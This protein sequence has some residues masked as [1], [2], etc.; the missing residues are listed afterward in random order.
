MGND[1]MQGVEKSAYSG[2]TLVVRICGLEL[3]PEV[4]PEINRHGIV[5][6]SYSNCSKREEE[7]RECVALA[8]HT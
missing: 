5:I 1:G 7:R 8:L 4:V 6:H 2:D 3:L